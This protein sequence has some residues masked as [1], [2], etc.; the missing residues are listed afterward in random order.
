MNRR[1]VIL[2][3]DKK[4]RSRTEIIHDIL[5]SAEFVEAEK[6]NREEEKSRKMN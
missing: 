1:S 4:Y 3:Q 2:T 6:K 5:R